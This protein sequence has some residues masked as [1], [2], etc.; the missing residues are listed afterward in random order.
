MDISKKPIASHSTPARGDLAV[1]NA[2]EVPFEI[3]R[4]FWINRM[5]L[6]AQRG[7]HAHREGHQFLIAVGGSVQIRST[8]P[9]GVKNHFMLARPEEGLYV[10]P[11]HW[12]EIV[13]TNAKTVLLCLASNEYNEVDYVRDFEEFKALS[14]TV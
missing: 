9:G 7:K 1:M 3:K 13:N 6:M 8:G 11:M 2:S 5:P 12:L 4:L 14:R 10:P